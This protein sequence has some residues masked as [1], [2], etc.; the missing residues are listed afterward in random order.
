MIVRNKDGSWHMC[1]GYIQLK[2]MNIK[3]KFVIPIIVELLYEF[4]GELFFSM[5][6]LHSGYHQI[7]MR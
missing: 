5:L 6:D 3:Y 1:L 2:K 7:R 4:H